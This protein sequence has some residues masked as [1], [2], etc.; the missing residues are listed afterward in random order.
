[1]YFI[2]IKH[3]ENFLNIANEINKSERLAHIASLYLL[4]VPGIFNKW[5]MEMNEAD[6]GLNISEL[7]EDEHFLGNIAKSLNGQN[8]IDIDQIK[9]LNSDYYDVFIQ[10]LAIYR[11]PSIAIS[12][13]VPK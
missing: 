2:D 5:N 4:S 1:M 12:E 11:D 6:I 8:Q 10:A 7:E 13:I 9:N 3:Q